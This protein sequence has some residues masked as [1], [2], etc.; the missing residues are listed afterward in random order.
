MPGNE[1][2]TIAVSPLSG[3]RA[4]Y[5]LNQTSTVSGESMRK[6]V[7]SL[8]LA[9][10]LVWA[11]AFFFVKTHHDAVAQQLGSVADEL[12][13]PEA[14]TVVSEHVERERFICFNSKPCPTLSRT[15]QTDRVLSAEDVLQLAEA[16]GWD[17]EIEGTCK[18]AADAAGLSSVCSAVATSGGHLIQLQVDSP[19]PGAAS[20]V[21][22]NLKA[23]RE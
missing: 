18:R 22:M 16:T 1:L 9:M 4:V 10:L 12:D 17:F 15:W 19:E 6:L 21:R 20:L 8:F 23:S 14:W 5:M 13:V 11:G 7:V 3:S 2:G